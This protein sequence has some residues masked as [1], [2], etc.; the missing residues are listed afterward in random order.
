MRLALLVILS[1]YA[2]VAALAI[3]TRA[4]M[5]GRAETS[6]L[7]LVLWNAI[8]VFP[9]YILGLTNLLYRFA[10]AGSVALVA[11]VVIVVCA[12]G[13]APR[14][15]ASE[16][17]RAALD[18]VRLPFLGILEAARRR[19]LITVGLVFGVALFAWIT[20]AAWYAPPRPNWDEAWYHEPT[21]GWSIQNHGFRFITA[22]QEELPIHKTNGY[23]RLC[24]VTQTWFA[25]FGGRR[26]L[27]FANIVAVP[28]MALASYCLARRFDTDRL[29]AMAFAVSLVL[30]PACSSFVQSEMVDAQSGALIMAAAYFATRFEFRIRDAWYAAV[31]LALAVGSKGHALVPVAAFTLIALVRLFYHHGRER[32]AAAFGAVG[33]GLLFIG[34][35][36]CACH[37]RNWIAFG[38]P[39]WPDLKVDIDRLHVHWPGTYEWQPKTDVSNFDRVNMNEP[40]AVLLKQLGS[41]PFSVPGRHIERIVDYGIGFTWVVLP[42]ACLAFCVAP[43]EWLVL[44]VAAWWKREPVPRAARL[45]GSALLLAL[46]LAAMVAASPALWSPR[47]N[48]ASVGLGMG[49]VCWLVAR[50]GWARLGEG[51][52]GAMVMTTIMMC[53]WGSWW[54]TPEQ[55]ELARKIPYPERE[56]LTELGSMIP[57]EIGRA[58]DAELG[59]GKIVA[60]CNFG[61]AGVLWNDD[62]SNKVVH[63]DIGPNADVRGCRARAE[64]IRA[65]WAACKDCSEF[66]G[67]PDWAQIGVATMFDSSFVFRYVGKAP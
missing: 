53:V 56:V 9:M 67:A 54:L 7:A 29:V 32:R 47:Y 38:N 16:V 55:L 48:I 63:L 1:A 66:N 17:G 4:R 23:P 44:L 10:V 27:E 36:F 34:G 25:L 20:I 3:A 35:I 59:P 41:V 14:P 31:A 62:Y 24:E 60:L 52:A 18:F 65:T 49:L 43:I 11:T 50:P 64:A 15:F 19:S 39:L 6:L 51:A 37:L 61:F 2:F 40:L 28:T 33:A 12:W 26:L 5:A 13:N 46:P 58:R 42:L 57:T 22:L 8:I 30:M 45:A 21:V